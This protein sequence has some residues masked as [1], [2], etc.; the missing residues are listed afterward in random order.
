MVK[1]I[2][3]GICKIVCMKTL[4]SV[5]FLVISLISFS[6][7]NEMYKSDRKKAFAQIKELKDGVLVLRLTLHKKNAELYR[8]AGNVK[9]ADKL[10]KD[11]REQNRLLA[12]TFLDKS[13]NF[14]PV[15]IIEASNYGRVINGDASG[16]FLDRNLN[17]DS[18]ITLTNKNI[19]FIEIGSVYEVVRKDDSFLKSEVSST[20]V[21]QNALVIKDKNM[22]QLMKPFPFN[23]PLYGI[24][25][26]FSNFL[27]Y[28]KGKAA[29]DLEFED[30]AAYNAYIKKKY[31]MSKNDVFTAQKIFN[32]NVRL[33]GF[34]ES[35]KKADSKFGEEETTNEDE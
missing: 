19:Y 35:A 22:E 20:P 7:E 13:F 3:F 18:S 26:D 16:F 33:F 1:E 10:E 25:L 11:L 4:F 27:V 9:L 32:L 17:V 30:M 2:Q 23:L 28:N 14:C 6:Q 31:K 5:I 34:L 21:I 24:F 8:A 29:G 15:Y 12:L